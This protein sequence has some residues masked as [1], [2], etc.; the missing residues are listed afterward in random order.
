MKSEIISGALGQSLY[1]N[2]RNR[3]FSQIWDSADAFIADYTGNGIPPI[4]TN[5]RATVLYYLLFARYGNSTIASS[6]EYQFKMNVFSLVYQYGP[7][8]DKRLDIQSNLRALSIDE[9]QESAKAIYNHAYNPAAAPKTDS[10]GE[11]IL[12]YIN[13]QNVTLHKRSKTDA[14]ALLWSLLRTDVTEEFLTKFRKLFLVVVSPE[15]PLWYKTQLIN[16]GDIEDDNGTDYS[17]S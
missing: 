3:T 7:T 13:D 16:E 6:D 14:Y 4:I 1:G 5:E 10:T 9:L 17:N 12:D 8:W 11:H 2:Y 15:L